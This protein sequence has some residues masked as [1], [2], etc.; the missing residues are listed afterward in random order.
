MLRQTPANRPSLDEILKLN[1]LEKFVE[2]Y[3]ISSMKAAKV[4]TGNRICR[5]HIL[6]LF[7]STKLSFCYIVDFL[8]F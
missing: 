2:A 1:F 8:G 4:K 7:T 6:L 5:S 3:G